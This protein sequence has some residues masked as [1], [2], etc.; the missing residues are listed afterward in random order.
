MAAIDGFAR[1]VS[2]PAVRS[3]LVDHK[4]ALGSVI[5]AWGTT[6]QPAQCRAVLSAVTAA[7]RLPPIPNSAAQ[8]RWS[9]VVG[10]LANASTACMGSQDKTSATTIQSDL[11]MATDEMALLVFGESP[12][13][14]G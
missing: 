8:V 2:S 5:D 14:A 1:D 3:W 12:P 6:A 9:M 10:D 4:G 13:S 7:R 11:R